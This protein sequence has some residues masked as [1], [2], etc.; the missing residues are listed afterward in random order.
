MEN[1]I[2][3]EVEVSLVFRLPVMACCENEARQFVS[4]ASVGDVVGELI[5]EF[6]D[7]G[8]TPDD[9]DL[10]FGEVVE[11]EEEEEDSDCEEDEDEEDEEDF[12]E[13]DEE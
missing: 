9:V 10:F 4:E 11:I 3:F 13:D 1:L 7:G 6:A 5:A 2:P 8:L 12:E